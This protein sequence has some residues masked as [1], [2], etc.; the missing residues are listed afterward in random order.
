MHIVPITE[1]DL[2]NCAALLID[3]Y[4]GPPWEQHWQPD[5]ALR[6]LSELFHM[7][8]FVG[9]ALRDAA[10]GARGAGDPG[11]GA[12][13]ACTFCHE[14][15]WWNADEVFIDELYVARAHQRQGHGAR[16]LAQIETHVREHGL[17]GVTLLTNRYM[18]APAFY[19]AH[20]YAL[21][22]HVAFMYKILQA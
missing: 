1:S 4:N 9:W 19:E 18:P 12:L 22:E 3:A 11:S 8:R 14:R 13:A 2:P 20:G 15:T 17:A 5:S 16:L 7:P 21:G 6:Y 10:A